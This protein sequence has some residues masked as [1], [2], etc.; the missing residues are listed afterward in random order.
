MSSGLSPNITPH[1]DPSHQF[2]QQSLERVYSLQHLDPQG[3]QEL[4]EFTIRWGDWSSLSFDRV[5]VV[6]LGLTLMISNV[7]YRLVFLTVDMILW[8]F[9]FGLDCGLSILQR[10]GLCSWLDWWL[11]QSKK[12]LAKKLFSAFLTFIY[13]LVWVAENAANSCLNK[14]KS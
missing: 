10:K 14:R 12:E 6:M 11:V 9:Y 7:G 5:N 13:I 3:T 1:E 4:L 8:C 2:L